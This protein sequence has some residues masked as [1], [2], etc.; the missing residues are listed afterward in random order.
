MNEYIEKT[1]KRHGNT[2]ISDSVFRVGRSPVRKVGYDERLTAPARKLHN[3]G[4]P[5]D[6]ISKAIASAFC[7]YNPEDEEAVEIQNYIKQHGIKEAVKHF[8]KLED[9]E[10]TDII[11]KKY[12]TVVSA[13]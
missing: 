4:L 3:M 11:V 9:G 8:T 1:L 12:E 2:S 6:F 13:K 7:F 10:L 5:V